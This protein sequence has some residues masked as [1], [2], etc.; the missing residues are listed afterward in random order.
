M[1]TCVFVLGVISCT[2]SGPRPSPADAAAILA[3]GAYVYIK[4]LPPGPTVIVAGSA[5]WPSLEHGPIAW[6]DDFT[7]SS[8]VGACYGPGCYGVLPFYAAPAVHRDAHR[9]NAS[10]QGARAVGRARR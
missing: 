6:P 8:D 1:T 7:R 10:R 4:P 3:P 9:A 2:M 5:S